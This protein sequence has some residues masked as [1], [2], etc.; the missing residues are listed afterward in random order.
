MTYDRDYRT[1]NNT[2]LTVG[3]KFITFFLFL[4]VWG[5]LF[6]LVTYFF[7]DDKPYVEKPCSD[8]ANTEVQYIPGRC[9]EGIKK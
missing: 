4:W 8:Y 6:L 1:T 5:L 3:E 2:K 7:A 9:I